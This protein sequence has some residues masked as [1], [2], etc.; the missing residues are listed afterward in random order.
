MNSDHDL[1][2]E[3]DQLSQFIQAIRKR[4]HT[5]AERMSLLLEVR[6][7][8]ADLVTKWGESLTDL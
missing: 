8:A 1:S 6:S 7:M 4:Q 3:L 5:D 2:Y